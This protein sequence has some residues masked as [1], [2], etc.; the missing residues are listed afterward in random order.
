MT[1]P[2]LKAIRERCER[3]ATLS[4][5]GVYVDIANKDIPALLDYCEQIEQALRVMQ[6]GCLTADQ[7]MKTADEL[8]KGEWK[9]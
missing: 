8:L 4:E 6:L 5:Y 3:A 9:A 1:R 2:D 7:C